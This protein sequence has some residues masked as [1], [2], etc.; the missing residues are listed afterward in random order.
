[1]STKSSIKYTDDYHVY[2]E[3]FDNENIY[4]EIS[5]ISVGRYF[6]QNNFLEFE[7]TVDSDVWQSLNLHK[8]PL[9]FGQNICVQRKCE[10]STKTRVTFLINDSDIIIEPY[11]T[12]IIITLSQNLYQDIAN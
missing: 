3:C 2:Y 6:L 10:I 7:F 1:M 12:S 5:N 11:L 9:N 8:L 4:I